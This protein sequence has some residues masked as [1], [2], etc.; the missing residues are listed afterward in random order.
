MGEDFRSTTKQH[1]DRGTLD[2]QRSESEQGEFVSKAFDEL[3]ERI[4]LTLLGSP[5]LKPATNKLVCETAVE[6]ADAFLD[7]LAVRQVEARN[8]D[9]LT[10][11]E[12]G[13][14]ENNRVIECIKMVRERTGLNLKESKRKV[15]KMRE[16]LG[17]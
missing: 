9:G 11:E 1:L 17:L 15:D 3:A 7:A 2:Q 14:L 5:N 13:L 10:G 4:L 12:I 8:F 6:L 16:Q